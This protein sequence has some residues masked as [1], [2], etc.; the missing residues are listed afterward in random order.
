MMYIEL[1][2]NREALK[3]AY[4]NNRVTKIVQVRAGLYY[5]YTVSGVHW[6]GVKEV[7]ELL[8]RSISETRQLQLKIV[9]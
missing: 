2:N 5:I 6:A 8:G 7:A 1:T 4:K 3:M 9:G